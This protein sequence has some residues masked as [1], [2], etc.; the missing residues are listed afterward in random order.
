MDNMKDSR[1]VREQSE[2]MASLGRLVSAVV[3]E[4]NTPVGAINSNNDLLARML[5]LLREHAAGESEESRKKKLTE[6]VETLTTIAEVDRMA[7]R[8]IVDLVRNVKNFSRLDRADRVPFKLQE[9]LDNTVRLVEWQFKDRIRVEKAYG[10][11]P[12]IRCFPNR[13]NQAFLNLLVN[14]GEAI[15]GR[16]VITIATRIEGDNVVV[17]FSDTGKGIPDEQREKIFEADFTTKETGTGLGLSITREIVREHDGT[18][19][20]ESEL[21]KGT[22]FRISLPVN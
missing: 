5:P 17:E 3:H 8:R 7:V 10:D 2:K 9:G 21:G 14:A 15:E 12:K 16:G 13:L 1:R 11:L 19:E 4:I 6:F 22:V 18:I 20:V